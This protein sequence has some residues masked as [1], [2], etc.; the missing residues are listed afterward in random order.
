MMR[1]IDRLVEAQT[2]KA[3]AL[4]TRRSTLARLAS[5]IF[6]SAAGV[7]LLPIARGRASQTPSDA[8]LS[9]GKPPESGDPK[10][11]DYWRY[12][13]IDGFLSSC[14]GGTH[15]SCPPGTEPSQITWIGT[16][17]NP[18]DGHYYIISYNDCCG[19]SA[20]GRCECF[21]NEG[22]MPL[23]DPAKS[24]D[25]NWCV[26]TKSKAYNSTVAL[27]IGRQ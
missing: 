22:D 6:V 24:N 2:R 16:C 4:V 12:C 8:D 26:G 25:I 5:L 21:R 23:Y 13:A 18:V 3:A 1:R 10:S 17:K 14:C 9:H 7:P 15:T 11:C 19:K 27:V 20:C